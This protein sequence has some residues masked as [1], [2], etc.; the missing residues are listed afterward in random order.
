MISQS[1]IQI[2]KKYWFS[3]S[4]TNDSNVVFANFYLELFKNFPHYQQYFHIDM[5]VQAE[6]LSSMVNIIVNGVEV[7]DQLEPEIVRL[8]RM[9]ANIAD[10]STQDYQ[11][12]FETLF[13][14]MESHRGYDDKTAYKAWRNL[15]T[16]ISETM[17]HA[18]K[19]ALLE[20]GN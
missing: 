3:I 9:H 13:S 17:M 2:V 18:S 20:Q 4:I 16:L 14:A 8:G 1:D 5:S 11:N 10:F 6:K 12:I 15:F 7:W 19:K